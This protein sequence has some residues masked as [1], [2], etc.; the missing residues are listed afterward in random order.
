MLS[1]I[2][3]KDFAIIREIDIDLEDG[4]N[5]ITGETGTGKSVV[6]QAISTALGGRANSSFVSSGCERAVIQLVFNLSPQELKKII[7]MLSSVG[8]CDEKSETSEDPHMRQDFEIPHTQLDYEDPHTQLDYESPHTQLD[9]EDTHTQLDYED[10][11]TQLD[12]DFELIISRDILATGKSIARINGR[13]VTLSVLS[14][15][16]SN[17]IDI[18]GQYDNHLLKN[19]D[20]HMRILDRYAGKH[21]SRTLTEISEA[22][23]AYLADRH[24]LSTLRKNHSEWLRKQD[25][26]R[27][28]HEEISNA[29][30]KQ[31]E[32][33]I[34]SEQLLSLQNSEKIFNAL[35]ES[36]ELLSETPLGRCESLL[37][38]ISDYGASYSSFLESV[39]SCR[40]AVE[41]LCSEIRRARDSISPSSEDINAI[42]ERL[43]LIDRLKRKYGGSINAILEYDEKI[44]KELDSFENSEEK[45]MSLKKAIRADIDRL[46]TLSLNL[47]EIRKQA[48][49]SLSKVMTEHL[50]ELNFKNVNFK[51]DISPLLDSN[52]RK[53][54]TANGCDEISFLFSANKGGEMKPLAQVAS[55]GEI[56]RISLAF[57]CIEN[58]VESSASMIF[59][60]IDTGISGIT[61]SVV[62]R[63][64]AKLGKK[65]QLLCI[66][67]LPQIA[68]SGDH[69]YLISKDED[70]S[71]SYTTIKKL[72]EDERIIEISRLL[73]G[74][75]VTKN[76]ITSAKELLSSSR[77]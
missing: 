52:G 55:G 36:Y 2:Y 77:R 9:Y 50:L 43:D 4:L 70:D 51:C 38:S 17:L 39:Q 7:P 25:F 35:S 76:T 59:D 62:G 53:K 64:M 32:D 74:D 14:R 48:A 1:H 21:A 56:S 75:N 60:E 28:E 27:Y 42:S 65:H 20:E 73:G 18:H 19:E 72:S 69:Q 67:H 6:I 63:K 24:A 8:I 44:K 13:I 37:Q 49:E 40:Y 46:E 26:L 66:T 3:I 34:L 23:S 41:D 30:I 31:G 22:Y 12:S 68:A 33:I 47:T 29:A 16:T 10:T 54:Y 45:E 57:K 71:G 15:I 5:I 11:H 58:G 61:A